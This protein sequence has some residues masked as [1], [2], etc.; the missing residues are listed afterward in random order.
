[1]PAYMIAQVTVTDPDQYKKY[2]A[3]TPAL[4]ERFGGRFLVRGG[5]V[6]TLE[7]PS[8][9]KRLVIVEWPDTQAAQAMFNSPEYQ[10][11]IAIRQQ[12]S[13]AQFILVD[14]VDAD[15]AQADARVVATGG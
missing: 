2:T 15:A 10:A 13:E 1:M 4:I 6:E 7:G 9:D 5:A 12:G 14:G 8:F 3:G 11:L